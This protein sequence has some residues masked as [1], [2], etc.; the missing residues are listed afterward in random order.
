[1]GA[2]LWTGFIG[3]VVGI[4]AKFLLPGR[5]GPHGILATAL[6]GIAGAYVGTFLGQFL[7]FYDSGEYAGFGGSILGAVVLL[8]LWGLVFKRKPKLPPPVPPAPPP[9]TPAA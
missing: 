1:M 3:L 4:I 7:G 9:P 5:N 6:L 2:F 8:L